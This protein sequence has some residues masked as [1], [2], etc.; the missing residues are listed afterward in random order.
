M[1]GSKPRC[2]HVEPDF[3]LKT[4]GLTTITTANYTIHGHQLTSHCQL[5]VTQIVHN[6]WQFQGKESEHLC[7]YSTWG[8]RHNLLHQN[9]WIYK[10]LLY[11][12]TDL[13]TWNKLFFKNHQSLS[14][15]IQ[16]NTYVSGWL[17]CGPS[18]DFTRTGPFY[19]TKIWLSVFLAEMRATCLIKF[20]NK[21]RVTVGPATYALIPNTE[22]RTS[23]KSKPQIKV[24]SDHSIYFPYFFTYFD[25]LTFPHILIHNTSWLR[26][27]FEGT[28]LMLS[29]NQHQPPACSRTWLGDISRCWSNRFHR[30]PLWMLAA[31][32]SNWHVSLDLVCIVA[33]QRWLFIFF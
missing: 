12:H 22:R 23:F 2:G 1:S 21:G 33:P 8:Y 3:P 32:F 5:L 30:A 19:G 4:S 10:V 6:S 13:F 28:K 11:T 29:Q 7:C 26:H 16:K 15:Q 17:S 25:P 24:S 14:K 18:I 31:M 27:V 20:P 9:T